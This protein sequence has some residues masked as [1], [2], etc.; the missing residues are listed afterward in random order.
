MRTLLLALA[1]TGVASPAAAQFTTTYAGTETVNGQSVPATATFAVEDGHVAM[2]MKGARPGRMVFDEK[3][4]VL[5]VINDQDKTYLDLDKNA[6][7]RGDPM[8]MMQEQM[9]KMP[10]DQ[11]AMMEGMMKSAMG[12]MPPPLTYVTSTET[13]TVDGYTCTRVDGMRGGE[14]VTEYCGSTSPDLRMS[15]AERQ[16][17]LDMQGYLRNFS[18]MV[19][20][21]DD[22]TR[23]FQ[24]DTSTDGYP[25]STRCFANGVMTLDLS[26]QSVSRQPIP[27]DLFELPK[28]YKKMSM[29]GMG[30]GGR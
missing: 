9:A 21:A 30:R 26:L 5:H 28:G 16:T 25:V 1:L 17:M 6:A 24:W 3:A 7:G 15:G 19:R 4:G 10:A 22:S 12:S 13:R 8:A 20:S 2:I 23:A 29:P 14:K 27:K 18:I 11:R